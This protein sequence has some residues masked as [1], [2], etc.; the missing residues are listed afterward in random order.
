MPVKSL[1]TRSLVTYFIPR[2][3]RETVLVQIN[4][5]KKQGEDFH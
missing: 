4:A 3:T 1:V 5:A 2:P